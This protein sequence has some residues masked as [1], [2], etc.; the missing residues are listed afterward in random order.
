MA[1]NQNLI[2]SFKEGK[3]NYMLEH[4]HHSTEH[5]LHALSKFY[6]TVSFNLISCLPDAITQYTSNCSS[7]WCVINYA[8]EQ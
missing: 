7:K 1:K 4:P 8:A 6:M 3:Q 5:R 2:A